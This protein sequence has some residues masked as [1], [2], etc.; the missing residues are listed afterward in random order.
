MSKLDKPEA[1]TAEV[2]A[3]VADRTMRRIEADAAAARKK[4]DPEYLVRSL[5][6]FEKQFVKGPHAPDCPTGCGCVVVD[7][8]IGR[9]KTLLEKQSP[10]LPGIER[11]REEDRYP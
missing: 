9:I 5:A 2:F 6:E 1:T 7:Q 8:I 11:T 10:S 3:D 4:G